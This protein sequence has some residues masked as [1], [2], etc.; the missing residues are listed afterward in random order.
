MGFFRGRGL[1]AAGSAAGRKLRSPQGEAARQGQGDLDP[2][3]QAGPQRVLHAQ[4][5]GGFR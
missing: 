2:G 5:E 4:A 3:G 1:D